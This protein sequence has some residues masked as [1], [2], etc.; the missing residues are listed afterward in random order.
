VQ[1]ERPPSLASSRRIIESRPSA[2]PRRF[3]G[4]RGNAGLTS[5]VG[6][7]LLVLLAVE[8]ATILRIQQLLSVHIFIG[9]LLLGPVTLKLASTGYRFVRYYGKSSEYVKLGPPAPLMRFVVAPVLVFSTLTLFA[10]GIALLVSPQRGTLL[11]LHKASFIV[12]FGAMTLHVLTYG[13]R[14]GRNILGDFAAR[15]SDGWIYRVG[16]AA[17]AIVAG[18]IAAIATYPLADPWFHH[19]IR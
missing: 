6:S 2:A 13:L 10:S 5:L 9:M 14:A 11:L 12:W 15:R 4:A 8:G 1:T 19:L 16:L 17:L 7:I 3:A 18:T